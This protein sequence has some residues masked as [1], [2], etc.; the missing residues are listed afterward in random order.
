MYGIVHEEFYQPRSCETIRLVAVH[1][2]VCLGLQSLQCAKLQWYRAT[3][4]I[5]D[6]HCAP[7][8]CVVHHGAHCRPIFEPTCA[9]CTLGSHASLS[10][11][12]LSRLDQ[13]TWKIIYISES[14]V[15]RKMKVGHNI[16]HYKGNKQKNTNY[17]LKILS[18]QHVIVC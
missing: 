1:L 17:T 14:I 16:L 12:C 7:P 13:K 9:I 5:I 11:F 2:F 18:S 10:V 6:L 8:T 4:C 3:L 15:V